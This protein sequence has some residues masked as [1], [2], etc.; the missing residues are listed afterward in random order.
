MMAGDH[1][2]KLRDFVGFDDRIWGRI[3]C[4][5]VIGLLIMGTGCTQWRLFQ[6]SNQWQ[7]PQKYIEFVSTSDGPSVR[8]LDPVVLQD[9][10]RLITN[11]VIPTINKRS[12][13]DEWQFDLT[14]LPGNESKKLDLQFRLIFDSE[15]ALTQVFYPRQFLT[16]FGPNFVPEIIKLIGQLGD[17]SGQSL[18]SYMPFAIADAAM[19]LR[20]K[21]LTDLGVPTQEIPSANT[22][23]MVYIY[24]ISRADTPVYPYIQFTINNKTQKAIQ[25]E[26][27][28]FGPKITLSTL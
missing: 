14:K 26:M 20:K 24:E 8:F 16:L 6:F 4:L 3:G 9:D 23:Q 17:S 27:T 13:G 1:W 15:G 21:I 11:G 28:V 2:V 22:T 18:Q 10:V 12:S 19:P 7:N 25:L 5:G